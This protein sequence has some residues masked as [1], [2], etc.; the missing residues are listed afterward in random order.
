MDIMKLKP[1]TV[2]ME[3]PSYVNERGTTMYRGLSTDNYML[4]SREYIAPGDVVLAHAGLHAFI[5]DVVDSSKR[6]AGYAAPEP[7]I[8]PFGAFNI[9]NSRVRTVT[10]ATP[11][12]DAKSA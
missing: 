8:S 9:A 4:K 2:A 1:F 10:N 12:S 11:E 3:V 6:E 7:Q 5:V